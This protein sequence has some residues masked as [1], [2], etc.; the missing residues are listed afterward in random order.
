MNS[1]LDRILKKVYPERCPY[2]DRVIECG[3]P[4]CEDCAADF[5]EELPRFFTPGGFPCRAVFYYEGGYAGAVKRLKFGGVKAVGSQ[6]AVPLA[7]LIRGYEF[8][9]DV[10]TSVPMFEK[11]RRER[12]FN[13]AEVI[14]SA[15]A[16]I[17]G[18][19][20]DN[21]LVKTKDN[22]PQHT[23]GGLSQRRA[24]V[25]NVYKAPDKEKI[26]GKSILLIDDI[27]TTGCT[28][29][30]CARVLSKA[31]AARVCCAVVCVRKPS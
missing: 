16:E 19:E 23:L 5:P 25:K 22:K 4:Y 10:V 17:L 21:L 13:H 7:K 14:A 27:F 1:F 31:G 29:G 20:Y 24:N 6:L 11:R 18:S 28:I 8:N 30:E 12:G 26:K 15:T 9:F 2:C 3:L